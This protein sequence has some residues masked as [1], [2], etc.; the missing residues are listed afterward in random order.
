MLSFHLVNGFHLFTKK[1]M[2]LVNPT[3]QSFNQQVNQVYEHPVCYFD[4]FKILQ[5]IM[6]YYLIVTMLVY[7]LN[8]SQ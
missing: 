6:Q 7:Y 2:S 8:L 4:K 1:T 5:L 3:Y